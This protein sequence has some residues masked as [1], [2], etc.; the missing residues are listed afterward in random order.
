METRVSQSSLVLFYHLFQNN[1]TDLLMAKLPS[2]HQTNSV[3]ALKGTQG[4]D[5]NQPHLS[6]FTARVFKLIEQGLTPH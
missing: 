3:K 6:C 2:C 5:P 4:T 1:G